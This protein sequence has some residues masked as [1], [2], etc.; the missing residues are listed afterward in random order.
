MR[1]ALYKVLAVMALL[2]GT[3][4]AQINPATQIK[5]P[6]GCNLPGQAYNFY[7]NACITAGGAGLSGLPTTGGTMTGPIYFSGAGTAST[8]WTN[9]LPGATTGML[10][11]MMVDSI[12]AGH[13]S[14]CGQLEYNASTGACTVPAYPNQVYD[15]GYP[16]Q[17]NSSAWYMQQ[18][19]G[20]TVINNG[21]GGTTLVQADARWCRD[22]LNNGCTVADD[23]GSTPT[24]PRKAD[25]VWIDG[26]TNDAGLGVPLATAE[27]AMDH[28]I[29]VSAANHIKLLWNTTGSE[30][31]WT[32]SSAYLTYILA[33]NAHLATVCS[34]TYCQI[35]D[36]YNFFRDP[37]LTAGGVNTAL[38]NF[39]GATPDYVHPSTAGYA[40]YIQSVVQPQLQAYGFIPVVPGQQL[41][42][43]FNNSTG[44]PYYVALNGGLV[45]N[46][47]MR[48]NGNIY[49][50]NGGL[51]GWVTCNALGTSC[52]FSSKI[53]DDGDGSISLTNAAGTDF[54]E[55]NLGPYD[56][57]HAAV[58]QNSFGGY[59][60]GSAA[61]ST[62]THHWY[63][64]E[65]SDLIKSTLLFHTCWD[66][67][68]TGDPN[69]TEMGHACDTYARTDGGT[70]TSYYVK[71]TGTES[72]ETNTGWAVVNTSTSPQKG[73]TG[74]IGGS[75]LLAGA[76][77]TGTATLSVSATGHT[78]SAAPSDGSNAQTSGSGLYTTPQVT[79][80]GT[81]ATVE[82]CSILPGTP[83]A[84]TYNVTVY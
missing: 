76:C 81:T 9:L 51:L 64:W 59:G 36:Y 77:A 8:T 50:V 20:A 31:S 40:W 25:W 61:L 5:W 43:Q 69:G 17:P 83:T 46:Q 84:V 49:A 14:V 33:L 37:T 13:P 38:M 16:T 19:T 70:G 24:I 28:I 52:T 62:G 82:I 58:K 63:S 15:I 34:G 55:L 35:F 18:I 41:Q 11:V 1:C 39:V 47:G 27:A 30:A 74:N 7:L 23:I 57:T 6:P 66:R 56:S 79:V 53:H 68:G 44:N 75:P 73:T 65:V 48:S 26:G 67:V 21:I 42:P 29:S 71:E 78:G 45:A 4:Q 72:A 3:A 54:L 2:C 10:G 12:S 32:G 60:I 80:N 22:V